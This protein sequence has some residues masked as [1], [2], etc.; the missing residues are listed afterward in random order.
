[1]S[2]TKLHGGDLKA[3][4]NSR[5]NLIVVTMKAYDGEELVEVSPRFAIDFGI[6]LIEQASEMLHND[7]ANPK[8]RA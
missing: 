8:D 4:T 7:I 6:E 1:M 3:R 2:N 5:E